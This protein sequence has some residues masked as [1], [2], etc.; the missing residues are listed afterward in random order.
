VDP[1]EAAAVARGSFEQMESPLLGVTY[2]AVD[3]EEF[4]AMGLAEPKPWLVENL[5]REGWRTVIVAREGLG[6]TWLL[7]Q[8]AVCAAY[9]IH[10]WHLHLVDPVSTLIIDL[11]NPEDHIHHSLKVLVDQAQKVSDTHANL[12][13]WS[14]PE[15]I[16][17]R[18]RADRARAEAILNKRRPQLVVLGP[19][20]KTH[21]NLRG[22]GW[23]QAA[24][25]VQAVLDSWRARFG[26]ALL[27]EDHAPKGEQIIPFGSSLWLRWPE[28]G[29]ALHEQK[30]QSLKVGRWRGDRMYTEWPKILVRS[31]PWPWEGRWGS[32]QPLHGGYSGDW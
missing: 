22:E 28:V 31:Q 32:L 14:R 20:Y 16:D 21:G 3:V 4:I 19:L 15:G 5:L 10:P 9:G 13:L 11:E 18:K 17:L 26:I 12:T 23:D 25:E 7:R 6:K 24:A 2:D 30:D 29:I 1:M 27:I 8:V